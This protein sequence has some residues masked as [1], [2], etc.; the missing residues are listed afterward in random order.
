LLS[1]IVSA[2]I[3]MSISAC[4]TTEPTIPPIP[5]LEHGFMPKQAITLRNGTQTTGRCMTL[6]DIHRLNIYFDLVE[7]YQR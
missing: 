5:R 2:M 6:E 7:V 3:L 4:A 1:V